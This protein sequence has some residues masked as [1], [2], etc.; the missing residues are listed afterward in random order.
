LTARE[1][2]PYVLHMFL[3]CSQS[4]RR[5]AYISAGTCKP[6]RRKHIL[7]RG[8]AGGCN[9]NVQ[10]LDQ[11]SLSRVTH[12]SVYDEKPA[13]FLIE[14]HSLGDGNPGESAYCAGFETK[15]WRCGQFAFHLVEWLPDYA[16]IEEDLNFTQG[17]S[18]IKLNQAAVRVYTSEKYKNRG[19]VGEIALHAVCRDFFGTI[20]ISPRVFYQSASNDVIKAFDMVHVR[21][22]TVDT[23]EIWL[24]E[25][26]IYEDPGSAISEAIKSVKS[27]IDAGFLSNEKLLLGPQIPKSTPNYDKVAALFHKST[28]LDE[29]VNSAVFVIGISTNSK[30][31]LAAKQIDE[32]YI[33]DINN[34]LAELSSKL[35]G[36]GLCKQVK[37][38]LVYIPLADKA[39]L[40][41]EFD[42]RLKGLQ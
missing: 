7:S 1:S 35:N 14:V 37:I 42:K 38:V 26:K 20:P 8:S 11:G 13:R 12:M 3:Y 27:H 15:Q 4:S 10:S 30:A 41:S 18:V 24:G 17:N 23:I 29:L 36:S 5:Q 31:A 6:H 32:C 28:S 22:P 40:I 16:L 25:S 33:S 19:E 34:E 21:F 2:E 39:A 9:R